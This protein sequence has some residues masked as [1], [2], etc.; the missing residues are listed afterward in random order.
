MNTNEI[1]EKA[2]EI[3]SLIEPLD[4]LEQM[5]VLD[6][7]STFRGFNRAARARQATQLAG[8]EAQTS[9]ALLDAP[10]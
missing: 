3:V 10:N 2:Q 6:L 8:T 4:D 9:N 1:V 7:A 5:A